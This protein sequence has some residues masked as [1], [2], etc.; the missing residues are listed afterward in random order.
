MLSRYSSFLIE[1]R[2]KWQGTGRG[3][4]YLGPLK[5]WGRYGGNDKHKVPIVHLWAES[6]KEPDDGREINQLSLTFHGLRLIFCQFQRCQRNQDV[7]SRGPAYHNVAANEAWCKGCG[8]RRVFEIMDK[9]WRCGRHPLRLNS[10]VMGTWRLVMA[11]YLKLSN[12]P[13]YHY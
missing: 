11:S 12:E 9:I 2:H 7:S 13:R 4:G 8:G 6:T 10:K 3:N 1:G 5:T